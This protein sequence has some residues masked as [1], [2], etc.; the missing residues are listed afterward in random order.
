MP[1]SVYG[2]VHIADTVSAFEYPRKFNHRLDGRRRWSVTFRSLRHSQRQ[3]DAAMRIGE[4]RYLCNK[5][6]SE[7][8]LACSLRVA[9]KECKG[10]V[11]ST[12]G[13]HRFQAKRLETVTGVLNLNKESPFPAS[14]RSVRDEVNHFLDRKIRWRWQGRLISSVPR[15]RGHYGLN[16]ARGRM[17]L[18]F[19]L[20]WIRVLKL[21]SGHFCGLHGPR[22]Y[23]EFLYTM[24][25]FLSFF[26]L[27]NSR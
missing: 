18:K 25:L 3:L 20:R 21:L 10:H 14:A 12:V 24:N 27:E 1:R 23:P 19:K 6:E 16:D 15:T 4:L 17:H 7:S 13:L 26:S 22:N 8:P 2:F 9:R 11:E 5:R